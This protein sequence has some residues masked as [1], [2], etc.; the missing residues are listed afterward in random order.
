MNKYIKQWSVATSVALALTLTF[1]SC[2]KSGESVEE[3]MERNYP[4]R[5]YLQGD[6][7][8]APAVAYALSHGSEGVKG[9]LEG[10]FYVRL[11]RAQAQDV[12]V[13][14]RADI[15]KEELKDAVSLSAA[16]V[17]V[18]AGQLASDE[19]SFTLDKSK[20]DSHS[21][22]ESYKVSI[23][24]DAIK[25]APAGLQLSTN[26]NLYAVTFSKSAQN[27]EALQPTID[28]DQVEYLDAD[29]RATKWKLLN[30]TPGIEGASNANVLFDDNESSLAA[31]KTSFTFTVDL[32]RV[33]PNLKAVLVEAQSQLYSPMGFRLEFS[34]DG[35][36]WKK[37]GEIDGTA[38]L[39][40]WG[41]DLQAM[42]LKKAYAA[43]YLRYTTLSPSWDDEGRTAIREF[44]V[45]TEKK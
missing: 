31:N 1:P 25:S 38:A 40:A 33:V 45:F 44:Y 6:R 27:E 18:K 35:K 21:D 22:N 2:K 36:K 29:E 42:T 20:L 37:F 30:V 23:M 39:V 5:V 12:V 10:R 32:G 3:L 13:T 26:R 7:Y 19:V 15:D 8:S 41:F 14:L 16:E 4:A 28:Y 43:R 11:S 17:T 24:V 9:T 34:E